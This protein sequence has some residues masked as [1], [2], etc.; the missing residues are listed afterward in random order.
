MVARVAAVPLWL[1][2]RDVVSYKCVP[3]ISSTRGMHKVGMYALLAGQRAALSFAIALVRR[4]VYV[5]S[6]CRYSYRTKGVSTLRYLYVLCDSRGS[7][8]AGMAMQM[9]MLGPGPFA[10]LGTCPGG[11]RALLSGK[12]RRSNGALC[13]C[14]PPSNLSTRASQ[15]R[16]CGDAADSMEL[17]VRRRSHRRS[18][19]V[20]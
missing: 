7:A 6:G 20:I 11:V 17:V 16:R 15:R 18:R 3:G 4:F 10:F 14:S 8:R 13:A 19:F 1:R 2:M 12:D 5:G 9:Q